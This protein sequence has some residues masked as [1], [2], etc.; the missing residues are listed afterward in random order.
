LHGDG[1]GVG[2]YFGCPDVDA[3]FE[4]FR[5]RGVDVTPPKI[6]SY[7]MKQLY[8]RDPDGYTLCFQWTA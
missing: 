8:V 7:G 3:A 1:L 4:H 2:L 6:A 5:R